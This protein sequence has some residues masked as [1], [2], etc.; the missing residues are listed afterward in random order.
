[1]IYVIEKLWHRWL[2]EDALPLWSTTGFDNKRNLFH[3]RLTFDHKPIDLPALRLMVQARQISTYCRA[4]VDGFGPTSSIALRCLE[5][6]EKRYWHSDGEIGWAFS[7]GPD[8]RPIDRR[9]DLYGHAFILYAYAWA[10]KVSPK[11]ISKCS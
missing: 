2:S 4:E 7:L 3:E 8:N 5:E 11:R 9:R 6:I 1:M 10:Y